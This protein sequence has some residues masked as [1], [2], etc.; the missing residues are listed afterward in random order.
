[1]GYQYNIDSQKSIKSINE[2]CILLNLD[3]SI[4]NRKHLSLE[5]K[6]TKTES[7]NDAFYIF[8]GD[9]DPIYNAS[10][11]DTIYFG[12]GEHPIISS[13]NARNNILETG[14]NYSEMDCLLANIALMIIMP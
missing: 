1:M 7:F 11:P 5:Y 4:G 14:D 2:S 9:L 6:T 12:P 10:D 8:I 13:S 3:S